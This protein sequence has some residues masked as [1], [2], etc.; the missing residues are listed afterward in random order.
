MREL[1]RIGGSLKR[2]SLKVSLER[3]SAQDAGMPQ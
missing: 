2:R 3:L 1:S